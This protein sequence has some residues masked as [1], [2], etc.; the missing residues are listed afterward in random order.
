MKFVLLFF[1]PYGVIT[2]FLHNYSNY[3]VRM[4]YTKYM[5]LQTTF[6]VM[7]I[8]SMSL[9]V[10]LLL[11]VVVLLIFIVKKLSSIY[12]Q[13]E[14][15]LKDAKEIMQ[16]PRDLAEDVGQAVV[17]TAISEVSRVFNRIMKKK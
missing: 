3:H 16:H 4:M 7:S 12:K 11:F 5:D 8:I 6:Y 1:V 15:R 17:H 9:Q 10:I 13:I 2:R 14:A